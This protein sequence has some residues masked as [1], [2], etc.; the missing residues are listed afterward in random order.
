MKV[1]LDFR[2]NTPAPQEFYLDPGTEEDCRPHQ[3][4]GHNRL[5]HL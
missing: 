3:V 1:L 2:F 4:A 5:L